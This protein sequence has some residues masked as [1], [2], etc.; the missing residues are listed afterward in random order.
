MP[1]ATD[2]PAGLTRGSLDRLLE[3]LG[4][5]RAGAAAEYEA[6]RGKL[7][8]FFDRRQVPTPDL[9]A[10]ETL[11][12]VAR[13]IEE[14]Q[15]IQHVRAF[16]Y[17]VARNVLLEW[18]RNRVAEGRIL[19][20]AAQHWTRQEPQDK[21]EARVG[22]LERCLRELPPDSRDLILKYYVGEGAVHLADRK[23][24]AKSLSV[25]Y[26]T[27]KTRAYRIRVQLEACLRRC[28]GEPGDQ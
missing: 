4:S 20:E 26:G 19:A 16:C 10:D 18:Q 3:R 15:D 27:L 1:L 14:G 23:R 28:L 5:D 7:T 8:D 17:G 6:V 21:I 24:L 13:K 25:S 11:D 12:R 9:L 2:R 22:C